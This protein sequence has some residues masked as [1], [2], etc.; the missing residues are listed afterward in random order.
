MGAWNFPLNLTL[1]PL[2]PAIAAGN[3]AVIKPSEVAPATAKVIQE[4]VHK[5]LDNDCFQVGLLLL[6][7]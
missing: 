1:S 2:C 3:C 4:L 7:R 6:L 5:Y